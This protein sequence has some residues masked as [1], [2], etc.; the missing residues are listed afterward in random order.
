MK[1]QLER[2]IRIL[3]QNIVNSVGSWDLV[4]LKKE[5]EKLHEKITILSFVEKY[6]VTLGV[7]EGRMDYTMRKVANFIEEHQDDEDIFAVPPQYSEPI[8]TPASSKV[9]RTQPTED[10]VQVQSDSTVAEHAIQPQE[11]KFA[12]PV[13]S[14][15]LEWAKPEPNEQPA[16]NQSYATEIVQSSEKQEVLP[17]ESVK[18]H[19]TDWTKRFQEDELTNVQSHETETVQPVQTQEILPEEPVRDHYADWGKR[20]QEDEPKDVHPHETEVVEPVETQEV[21]PEEP[22]RD[23]YADWGKR[24][25]EDEPTHVQSH[26]TEAPQPVEKQ[27]FT[28]EEPVRDH[29]AD[30][31]KRFQEDEPTHVQSHVTEAPQPVE[32]QEFTPEEPVRDH[33][34]EWAPPPQLQQSVEEEEQYTGFQ[35][36]FPETESVAETKEVSSEEPVRD[37]YSDWA[38]PVE[39]AQQSDVQPNPTTMEQSTEVPFE[40]SPQDYHIEWATPAQEEQQVDFQSYFVQPE[41]RERQEEIQQILETP[42]VQEPVLPTVN[43]TNDS[44]NESVIDSIF[45]QTQQL[46]FEKKEEKPR[47]LIFETPPTQSFVVEKREDTEAKT[48][49]SLNDHL[50]KNMPIGLNDRLA[51]IRYLF[52]GSESE[53]NAV[54]QRLNEMNSMSEIV[55]YL[56][57]NVKPIYNH[58]KGKDEYEE[59][60]LKLILKRFEIQ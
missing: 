30:W 27:E 32:K 21:L 53:Y 18:D 39:T 28:P 36:Q 25:Q 49:P 15:N 10:P 47:E 33:H 55:L 48:P 17:E 2:E 35:S 51:F 1:E 42:V 13:W 12:E 11:N 46:E 60:F 40:E 24:F 22:V 34:I 5:A 57:Q 56:E 37:H 20:F 7:T 52:L 29:Y 3:A 23:H 58:W 6:Y 44:K 50:G 26:V 14:K 45:S 9:E 19:Y 43:E 8:A 16:E 4:F 38:K 54:L 59:R 31:G 41:Q